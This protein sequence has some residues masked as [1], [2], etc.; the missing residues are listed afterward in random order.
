MVFIM[1]G[2]YYFENIISPEL[3]QEILSYFLDHPEEQK[4]VDKGQRQVRQYGY[5]YDY[6]KKNIGQPIQPFPDC[7]KKL[8][9]LIPDTD[10]NKLDYAEYFDQCIAN[11]YLSGEGISK[12]IDH[13]SFGNI[14]A[15]FTLQSGT[16]IEFSKG[17][18]IKK[19]YV[20]PR[21]LYIMRG[22]CRWYWAHQIRPRTRDNGIPRG[23]RWSITFRNVNH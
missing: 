15:C 2:L 5:A 11:R 23:I 10:E 8:L 20:N 22:Q 1:Q 21:S 3:E 18:D 13:K 17:S 14:I 19:I 16:E 4:P 7:V 6:G 12:H 9:H